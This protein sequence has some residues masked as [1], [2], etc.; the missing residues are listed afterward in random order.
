MSPLSIALLGSREMD[1]RQLGPKEWTHPQE[2]DCLG[3]SSIW[4]TLGGSEVK[5]SQVEGSNQR[6]R[7]SCKYKAS[8]E[9][10]KTA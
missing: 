3:K 6:L 1:G 9:L 10:N 2:C 7:R 8:K 4:G 5:S